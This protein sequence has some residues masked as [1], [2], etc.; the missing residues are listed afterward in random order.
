MIYGSDM[1]AGGFGPALL[2]DQ[3]VTRAAFDI[4][5]GK[6]KLLVADVCGQ[7]VILE[8]F[9]KVVR[10]G[11]ASDLAASPDRVL[12]ESIRERSV[13]VLRELKNE[14]LALGATQLQGIATA[15]FREAENGEAFLNSLIRETRIPL[16]LVSQEDEGVFGFHTVLALSPEFEEDSMI[17]WDSGS[18][19]FQIVAKESD[20]YAIYEGSLGVVSVTKAF[21]EE[22]RGISYSKIEAINPETSKEC[23]S[24]AEVIKKKITQ[25]DWLNHR[26]RDSKTV[27]VSIGDSGSIF[28]IAAKVIESNRYTIQQV[29]GVAHDLAGLPDDALVSL[30]ASSPETV[31]IRVVFLA[32]VMEVL[33]IREVL[34][35]ETLGSTLGILT[36][37]HFWNGII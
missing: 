27:V 1:Q 34:F 13:A 17:A 5:S 25:P 4:G 16:K 26:L 12:S 3:V 32:T 15:V 9:S 7:N 22:V 31:V 35:K 20:R 30:S 37:P 29:Q 18:A 19:S 11:L 10:V 8:K 2:S 24:L 28:S 36:T 6:F 14:A 21:L 33:G 23:Q